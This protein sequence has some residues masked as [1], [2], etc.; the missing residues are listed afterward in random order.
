MEGGNP[1]AAI[2]QPSAL[3]PHVFA[4][5]SG[6]LCGL[7]AL[8]VTLRLWTHYTHIRKLHA[9]DCLSVVALLFLIW[10]TVTFSLL[11]NVLNSDPNSVTIEHLTRLVAVGIASGNCAIYSAK[12]PLL[13]MLMRIFGIKRWLRW[14]CQFLVVFGTL[15]GLITLLYAGISCSPNLH[16]PT[17]PFLFS[18]VT[19]LTDAT[20]AR[21]SISLAIDV[22]VFI[23]PIPVIVGLKMPLRRKIGLSLAFTT[24]LIA[25]G[26]SAL[27]LYFQ[28]AQSHQSST[29]FANALLVTI[30]ESAIVIMV[31]CTPALHMFWTHHAGPLRKQLNLSSVLVSHKSRDSTS[32]VRDSAD[33]DSNSNSTGITVSNHY[34]V[35]LDERAGM[36]KL[37]DDPRLR[38]NE[39]V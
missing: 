35:E 25:I 28:A 24:G 17:P 20:I 11:I 39:F 32:K 1:I 12:L 3:R 33:S 10:N 29:N 13:F 22:I 9:D 30:I 18:C 7:T 31:S 6:G 37:S 19:A 23:L 8:I 5:L 36:E 16:R 21:G 4:G 14:T 26:A 34:Y 15:G 38:F 27:G 2:V